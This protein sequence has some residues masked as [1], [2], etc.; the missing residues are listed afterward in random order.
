MTA[1]RRL[2]TPVGTM[3]VVADHAHLVEVLLPNREALDEHDSGDPATDRAADTAVAQLQ[4]Y[5]A[6]ER[7]AFDLPL[8]PPGTPFQREVWFALAEIGYGDTTSYGELATRVGRP[9]A[10]RAIGSTNGR[11]PLP[12]VLPCHRVIGRDGSLT[13]YG[14]GLETK[15][16]LLD[17]ERREDPASLFAG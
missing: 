16:A 17:L 1:V 4:E 12:I 14:G 2:D 3:H 5:F 11:N 15:R 9:G 7:H 6:G 10:S 8:D 13:G